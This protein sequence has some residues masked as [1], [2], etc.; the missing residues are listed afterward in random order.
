MKTILSFLLIILSVLLCQISVA[1]E[2]VL[3]DYFVIGKDTTY[4]VALNLANPNEMSANELLYVD[5]FKSLKWFDTDSTSYVILNSYEKGITSF[6]IDDKVYDLINFNSKKKNL[7]KY[8]W[9]RVEGKITLYAD[10]NYYLKLNSDENLIVIKKNNDVLNSVKPIVIECLEFKNKYYYNYN[11]YKL[12][13]IV[14][15]YNTICK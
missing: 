5:N 2:K 12:E 14:R 10:R 8:C 15:L 6:R 1:Q 7:R 4:C 3:N 13:Y 9:K 11:M